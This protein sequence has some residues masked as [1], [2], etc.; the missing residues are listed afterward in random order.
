MSIEFSIQQGGLGRRLAGRDYVSGIVFA[1]ADADLPFGFSTTERTGKVESLEQAE[2]L[3]ITSDADAPTLQALHYHLQE[4]FFQFGRKTEAIGELWIHLYDADTAL[5]PNTITDLQTTAAGQIRQFYLWTNVA[6]AASLVSTAAAAANT[7]LG[8]KQPA[9][10]VVGA[11]FTA[12]TD[13]ATLPDVRALNRPF[14]SV[15]F[16]QDGSTQADAIAAALTTSLGAAGTLLGTI[17]AANVA[18]NIGWVREFNLADTVRFQTIKVAN[19]ASLP[20]LSATDVN[21]LITK[22]YIFV[23]RRQGISGA[24]FNDSPQSVPLD[25]DFAFIENSRTIQKA[26]REINAE[27]VPFINAPLRVNATTGQLTETTI[28][29]LESVVFRALNRMGAALEISV[30]PATG[31]LPN[32]AVFI[33]PDQNVLAASQVIITVRI[34]PV[35]VQRQT[36]VNIGFTPQLNTT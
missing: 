14:V 30:D 22:G 31:R 11:D 28:F 32:N 34:V 21:T 29:E 15:D 17:A 4:F 24:F 8:N 18:F 36:I 2:A 9:V 13:I 12:F 5:L 16:A 35:G 6:F 25:N 20:S 19:G 33:D 1:V 7:M 10:V 23:R 27:L 26:I 3:G